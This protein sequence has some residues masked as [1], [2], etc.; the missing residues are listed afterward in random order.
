MPLLKGEKLNRKAIFWHY[1]HY[2]G[3]GDSPAG[4]VREGNWKLIEFYEDNHVELYNLKNDIS[5]K[6][7][8]AIKESKI[9][10]RLL[11]ELHTWRKSV[12]AKMPI[13]NVNYVE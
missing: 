9:A 4:A 7:N 8:L 1:P 3:K 10:Q 6:N 2:G 5:E 13:K 11:S 12:G